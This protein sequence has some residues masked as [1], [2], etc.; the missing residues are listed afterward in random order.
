MIEALVSHNSDVNAVH[1]VSSA[2]LCGCVLERCLLTEVP[3]IDAERVRR[4]HCLHCASRH[5]WYAA[6]CAHCRIV[7]YC[8]G[9][10][11]RTEIRP[12]T[13]LH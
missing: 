5:F 3:A 8:N 13:S 2:R 12:F 4:L 9:M 6:C 1:A 10:L 7:L 11:R